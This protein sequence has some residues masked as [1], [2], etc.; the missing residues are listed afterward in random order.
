MK[1]FL[2]IGGVVIVVIVIGVAYTLYTSL[3]SIV[4]AAIEKYGSQYTGTAVGVDGVELDLTSG[5][6][7]INGFSVANPAG[8]ET[9]QAI[10]VGRVAIAVDIGSITGD[11]IVIKEIRIDQ[12]KVTYEIGPDG[13]NI[14]AIAQNVQSQ[15]GSGEGKAADKAGADEGGGGPKLIIEDLYVN[16]GEVGVS[17]TALKGKTMS[18][19][20]DDVHL[21]NI[22]KDD[23]GASPGKVAEIITAS[24]VKMVGVAIKTVDMDA[25]MKVI[26]GNTE[27]LPMKAK[28][29][30]ESVGKEAGDVG[31]TIGKEAGEAGEKLKKLFK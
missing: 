23:G 27:G 1:K 9:A 19:D 12:P 29:L 16:G 8:F 18:A 15:T 21:E 30:G 24:L 7:A 3:D 2:I 5:K 22:G 26:G 25:L 4:E 10:E 17:A 14:D 6:G 31:E 13:N 28:E 11:P 20:L